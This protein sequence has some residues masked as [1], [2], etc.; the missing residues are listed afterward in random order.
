MVLVPLSCHGDAALSCA[1]LPAA[2]GLH[3]AALD[4]AL[5]AQR[6]IEQE[7]VLFRLSDAQRAERVRAVELGLADETLAAERARI[8]VRACRI[9]QVRAAAGR[10]WRRRLATGRVTPCVFRRAMIRPA[11]PVWRRSRW[12]IGA[13]GVRAP[14]VTSAS[15]TRRARRFAGVGSA[16][17]RARIC[18]A[19]LGLATVSRDPVARVAAAERVAS[20]RGAE[21]LCPWLRRY[22]AGAGA[23]A[24]VSGRGLRRRPA[25]TP[26]GPA[27]NGDARV[28][29]GSIRARVPGLGAGRAVRRAS[30][31][32]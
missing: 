12:L 32:T 9:V 4:G 25:G 28:A 24:A 1:W 18:S 15:A 20:E 26:T 10:R 13:C 5:W 7:T 6:D 22:R 31:A 21:Q 17:R 30:R 8:E 19:G 3:R 29:G 2:R 23:P 16:R 27:L 11:W 14:R